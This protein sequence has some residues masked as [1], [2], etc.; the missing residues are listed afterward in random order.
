MRVLN[1][2]LIL[3]FGII[4]LVLSVTAQEIEFKGYG[5]AGYIFYDRNILN[6]YNQET[7]Y[8]GKLQADIE[9]NKKIEA[10]LDLRGN[11]TDN[12]V[13]LR[14]FSAKL[15]YFKYINFEIGNIKKPFGYE[16]QISKA[17][18]V[19]VNRSFVQNR[20]ED[21]GY[22]GRSVSIMGYYEYSKKRPEFPISY[23]LSLFK[24]NSLFAGIVARFG[25]HFNDDYVIS[26]NYQFQQKGGENKINTMGFGI[27]FVINKKDFDTSIEAYYV[28]DPYEGIRRKLQNVDEKVYAAG[29]KLQTAVG[30]DVDGEFIEEIEPFILLSYFL[31]D[32]DVSGN[33]VLQTLLGV[34]FYLTKD[35]RIRLNGDLRLTKN[36]FIDDYTTKESRGIFEFQVKF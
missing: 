4:S 24:N 32:I 3:L 11:S 33:H 26:A 7:Y 30:F 35:V 13:N 29:A 17:D 22:G 1:K 25:Y 15:K 5:A 23:F 8:E 16:Y 27:D 6:E 19:P 9:F 10:Q 12:S 31:P 34:N 2:A 36:Q 20:I 21:L 28:Q 14:E 18:L